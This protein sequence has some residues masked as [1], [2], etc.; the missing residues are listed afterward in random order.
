MVLSLY[1]GDGTPTRG[2][3]IHYQ[4]LAKTT[5]EDVL[6]PADILQNLLHID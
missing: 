1:V 2:R 4:T 3:D 6:Q 5:Y